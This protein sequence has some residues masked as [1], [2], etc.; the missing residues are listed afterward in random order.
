MKTSLAFFTFLFLFSSCKNFQTV[1]LDQ[2][3]AV[4]PNL[5]FGNIPSSNPYLIKTG[6][7]LEDFSTDDHKW[8][9]N[10]QNLKVITLHGSMVISADSIS[11]EDY[12]YKQ[13]APLDFS[14]VSA[15]VIILRSIPETQVPV[16]V[17]F[18]DIFENMVRLENVYPS[19]QKLTFPINFSK[20]NEIV[21]LEK[22]V[23]IR[24]VPAKQ[25]QPFVGKIFIDEIKVLE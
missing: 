21:E 4:N 16:E 14:L 9:K 19:E 5:V 6:G 8:E 3:G 15:L 11:N 25:A 17:Y 2:K 12:V 13:F 18:M 23:E 10:G 20:L 24:I 7:I 1:Q 22:I